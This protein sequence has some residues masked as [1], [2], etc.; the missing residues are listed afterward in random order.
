MTTKVVRGA[1]RARAAAAKAK[2]DQK[3]PVVGGNIQE[4]MERAVAPSRRRTATKAGA[5]AQPDAPAQAASDVPTAKPTPAAKVTGAWDK[6]ASLGHNTNRLKDA[7]A[8]WKAIALMA[9]DNGH[10][11]PWPDGGKLLR[12]RK[13]FL[14]GTEGKAPA[15]RGRKASS[16]E[17]RAERSAMTT[18]QRVEAS[19]QRRG[20][21]PWDDVEMDDDALLAYLNGKSI[22]W[23]YSTTGV[24]ASARVLKDSKHN[25]IQHG[26]NGPYITFVSV[27][28]PFM[29]VSLSKIITVS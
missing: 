3:D 24:E 18:D 26:E 16:P 10:D 17:D 5:K 15:A 21:M 19:L 27:E 25:R 7:G 1:G 12:A 6:E 4:A 22:T 11:I 8:T 20:H 14:A 13:Q 9:A 2:H 23:V 28:G 29:N